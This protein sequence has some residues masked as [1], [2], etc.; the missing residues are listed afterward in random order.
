M[1]NEWY[2]TYNYTCIYLFYCKG[3]LRKNFTEIA[4]DLKIYGIFRCSSKFDTYV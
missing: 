4:K 2:V 3:K 1:A